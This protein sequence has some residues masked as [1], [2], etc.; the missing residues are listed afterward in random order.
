MIA[1]LWLVINFTPYEKIIG[2]KIPEFMDTW[3]YMAM[4]LSMFFGFFASFIVWIEENIE[5]QTKT[6]M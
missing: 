5:A 2:Q 3:I 6:I 1:A 4:F